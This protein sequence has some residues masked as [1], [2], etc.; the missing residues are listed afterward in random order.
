MSCTQFSTPPFLVLKHVLPSTRLCQTGRT[1]SKSGILRYDGLTSAS[2]SVRRTSH[3]T[4][5]TIPSLRVKNLCQ[6]KE[7]SV[8]SNLPSS[9]D[10]RPTSLPSTSP[11]LPTTV[12]LRS[13]QNR[14]EKR[15]TCV[16]HTPHWEVG[17]RVPRR[18]VFPLQREN[19]RPRRRFRQLSRR[20]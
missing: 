8:G 13:A 18:W 3:T 11:L 5:P 2:Q 12:Q 1:L 14:R 6:S 7:M 4:T 16:R 10:H 15:R 20:P 19:I 17:W 9:I